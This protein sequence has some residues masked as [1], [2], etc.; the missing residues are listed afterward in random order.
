MPETDWI[1]SKH[2]FLTVLKAGKSKVRLQADSVS[3]EGPLPGSYMAVF[4]WCPHVAEAVR[5][6]CGVSLTKALIPLV[7]TLCL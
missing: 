7:G 3:G 4:S 2:L 5:G 1:I 6:L